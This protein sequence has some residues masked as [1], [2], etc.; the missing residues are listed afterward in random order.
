MKRHIPH[1]KVRLKSRADLPFID[2]TIKRLI[3]E[4]NKVKNSFNNWKRKGISR[5]DLWNKYKLLRNKTNIT[6]RQNKRLWFENKIMKNLKKG[7]NVWKTINEFIYQKSNKAQEVLAIDANEVNRHFTEIPLEITRSLNT[8]IPI[9]YVS[10]EAENSYSLPVVT[11]AVIQKTLETMND[12]RAVGLD[13]IPTKFLKICLHLIPILCF[14]INKSF[15]TSIVPQ[16]W[17]NARISPLFKG[18]SKLVLTN[19]RP[20]SILSSI[21]KI[22]ERI[23]FNSIYE[24]LSENSLLSEWQFG[25]RSG[26]SCSDALN[27]LQYRILTEKNNGRKVC[28]L[29]L[30]ISKAFDCVSHTILI[31]KLFRLGFDWRAIMWFTSYLSNRTQVVKF[32]DKTSDK[33]INN[34][35]VPQGSILGPLLFSIFVNDFLKLD[36]NG[37]KFCYADDCSI[38]YFGENYKEL[39]LK[40]QSSLVIINQWLT[41]HKLKLNASKTNYM[42]IDFSGRTTSDLSLAINGTSINKVKSTKILGVI[43]DSRI[44]FKEHTQSVVTK[45]KQRIGL[46]SRI[47][48]FV[49]SSVL[50][51]LYKARVQSTVDY[52]ITVYGYGVN[53]QIED[54]EKQ[55]RRA[56]RMIAKS[57][58]NIIEI[59]RQLNWKSFTQR[60]NYFTSIFIYKCLNGL[61]PE[62]CLNMFSFNRRG[63]NTRS[64]SRSDLVLPLIKT[65]TIENS[66]FYNGV[67]VYNSLPTVLRN[68]SCFKTFISLLKRHCFID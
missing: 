61:S 41:D 1:K 16:M 18:G 40:I 55:Q 34:I 7:D 54:I 36:V 52:C 13:G 42:I 47:K 46:I 10:V 24:Y 63:K 32:G 37:E 48:K 25:F 35:G 64:E 53:S 11:E 9:D 28:V 26:H 27:A 20:I 66:I 8:E 30:D 3:Y 39:E 21:T 67:K 14:I 50:N 29:S 23:L 49:S 38:V 6:I 57:N 45:M 22:F 58:Q 15:L 19:R 43:L 5:T 17:K 60:R 33:F 56:A 62:M 59:Y 51:I 68:N 44:S 65:R 4:R 31:Y 12:K 2:S